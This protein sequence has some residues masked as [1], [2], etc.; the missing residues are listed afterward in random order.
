M[1]N[2]LKRKQKKHKQAKQPEEQPFMGKQGSQNKYFEV[3]Q[4]QKSNQIAMRRFQ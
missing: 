4:K 2:K 3:Q 1:S